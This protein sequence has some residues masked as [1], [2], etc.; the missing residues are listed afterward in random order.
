MART[1]YELLEVSQTASSDAIAAN[2]ERLHTS[3]AERLAKGDEDASNLM[4]AIREAFSTL[5]N[6]SHRKRYDEK[7]ALKNY[8]GQVKVE[9][10]SSVFRWVVFGLLLV[11]L[12]FAFSRYQSDKEKKLLEL[13]REKELATAKMLE[14][15]AKKIEDERVALEQANRQRIQQ[16]LQ[17]RNERE[18]AIAYG[19]QVSRELRLAEA[20][21]E[22]RANYEK[23][24]LERERLS[25]AERQLAKEKAYLRQIELERYR[26]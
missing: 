1:L 9:Q 18:R 4:I 14:L 15:Q 3:L 2:Y 16:E 20:Q 7:L 5:S 19:N 6:P 8:E 17:E 26:N 13:E 22:S 24:R 10:P 25:D 21:S 12:A 23:Q 11:L